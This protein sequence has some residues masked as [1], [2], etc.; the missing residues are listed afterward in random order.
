VVPPD[1]TTLDAAQIPRE[2]VFDSAEVGTVQIT[3]NTGRKIPVNVRLRGFTED[4]ELAPLIDGP[5]EALPDFT[6]GLEELLNAIREIAIKSPFVSAA[7]YEIKKR[8]Y[9]RDPVPF[10]QLRDLVRVGH[11]QLFPRYRKQGQFWVAKNLGPPRPPYSRRPRDRAD[12]PGGS[13]RQGPRRALGAL[14]RD[15]DSSPLRLD[16]LGWRR[17]GLAGSDLPRRK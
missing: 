13:Q 15:R 4:G 1:E 5:P 16:G 2:T 12:A 9:L 17:L 11:I 10:G 7:D 6:I 14:L 8:L 3:D